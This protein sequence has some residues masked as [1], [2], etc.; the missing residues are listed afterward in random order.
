MV[1][2]TQP[3]NRLGVWQVCLWH[4]LHPPPPQ[5]PFVWKPLFPGLSPTPNPQLR[6]DALFQF[7][8]LRVIILHLLLHSL[9]F[10]GCG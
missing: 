10:L 6:E 7:L 8:G 5:G 1:S 4:F 9:A 3:S 2:Q